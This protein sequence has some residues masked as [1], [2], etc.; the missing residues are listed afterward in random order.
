MPKTSTGKSVTGDTGQARLLGEDAERALRIIRDWNAYQEPEPHEPG[1][2]AGAIR[3]VCYSLIM[4]VMRDWT[5]RTERNGVTVYDKADALSVQAA[6]S[7]LRDAGT[8]R[9]VEK[10]DECWYPSVHR[11]LSDGRDL[12]I[13]HRTY[14]GNSIYCTVTIDGET[15]WTHKLRSDMLFC[16]EIVP[17]HTHRSHKISVTTLGVNEAGRIY[18]KAMGGN[19]AASWVANNLHK[20][21]KE[22][23]L[24]VDLYKLILEHKRKREQSNGPTS[25]T[26]NQKCQVCRKPCGDLTA[27]PERF[28]PMGRL[29]CND[30]LDKHITP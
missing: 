30:C 11:V 26:Y 15:V 17:E 1:N 27:I 7:E 18:N 14:G 16:Y 28:D 22:P 19:Q 24:E 23:I 13:V 8:I 4:P 12:R 5:K 25:R 9:R 2:N 29:A 10:D 3:P 20:T 21:P 6:L